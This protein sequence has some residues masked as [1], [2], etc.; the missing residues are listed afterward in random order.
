VI[1]GLEELALGV[2]TLELRVCGRRNKTEKNGGQ[3]KL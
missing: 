3:K 2:V 1:E